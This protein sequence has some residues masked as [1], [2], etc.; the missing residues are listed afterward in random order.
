M[1]KKKFLNQFAVELNPE[2]YDAT[3]LLETKL[4][5][6][7][8]KRFPHNDDMGNYICGNIQIGDPLYDIANGFFCYYFDVYKI[9]KEG[10]EIYQIE[11][12]FNT[13]VDLASKHELNYKPFMIGHYALKEGELFFRVNINTLEIEKLNFD[14]RKHFQNIEYIN[15]SFRGGFYTDVHYHYTLTENEITEFIKRIKNE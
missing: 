3:E 4:I 8:Y 7:G 11:N 14:P 9:K 2:N 5:E 12:D 1:V 13:I 15:N 6:M 10:I